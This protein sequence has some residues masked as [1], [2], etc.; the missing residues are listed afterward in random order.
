MADVQINNAQRNARY[1]SIAIQPGGTGDDLIINFRVDDSLKVMEGGY[2]RHDIDYNNNVLVA[3]RR[4]GR[5]LPSRVS[6]RVKRG[7]LMGANELRT[8]MLEQGTEGIVPSFTT[9]IELLDGH[10]ASTGELLVFTDCTFE[11]G[12][13]FPEGSDNDEVPIEISAPQPF[14]TVTAI[15]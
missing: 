9:K 3:A 13:E 8:L 1:G 10:D 5:P 11:A 7:D 4:E 14:G 6:F 2:A 15:V 12:F